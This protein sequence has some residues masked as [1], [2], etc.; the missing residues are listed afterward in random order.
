MTLCVLAGRD[1]RHVHHAFNTG[2]LGGLGEES[3]SLND[4][5]TDGV[6]EIGP[7]RAFQGGANRIE[8]EEVTKDHLDPIFLKSLRPVILP[9]GKR[10]HRISAGKQ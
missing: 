5:G 8:V 1:L 7:T 6:A 10:P 2:F 9:M 4:P 3:S